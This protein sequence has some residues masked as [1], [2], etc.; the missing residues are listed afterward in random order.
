[1]AKK[2]SHHTNPAAEARWEAQPAQVKRRSQRNQARR[3]FEKEGK[4]HK[5]DG[6]E[7]DHKKFTRDLNAPL[8][9]S[10]SNLHVLSRSANRKK[11]PKRK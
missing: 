5:G 10:K 11:Q 9:N 4:V 6:K 1:M 8:D 7:V 3:E 2:K